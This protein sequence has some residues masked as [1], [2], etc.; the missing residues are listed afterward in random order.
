M[1]DA[2][3]MMSEILGLRW[4]FA[5][6]AAQTVS[7]EL[8]YV[9]MVLTFGG[10]CFYDGLGVWKPLIC[11]VHGSPQQNKVSVHIEN[12]RVAV[13]KAPH[14]TT[15]RPKLVP[16]I[17]KSETKS[18]PHSRRRPLLIQGFV[19]SS[20]ALHVCSNTSLGTICAAQMGPRGCI[21]AQMGP[22]HVSPDP[23]VFCSFS[24]HSCTNYKVNTSDKNVPGTLTFK[25]Q[26]LVTQTILPVEPVTPNSGKVIYK[27]I[28]W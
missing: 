26:L 17:R 6:R 13:S 9:V 4:D 15:C 14:R 12:K 2:H 16:C 24:Q 28:S 3:L 7:W 1:C 8:M 10:E 27:A 18:K 21:A 25:I 22:L 5:T 20:G 11:K 23:A 19:S